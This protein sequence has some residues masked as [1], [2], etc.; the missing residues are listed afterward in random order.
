LSH[1]NPLQRHGVTRTALFHARAISR[2]QRVQR[3]QAENIRHQQ[4]LMLLLVIDADLD[5]P[6]DLRGI[7]Q[8]DRKH[9]SQPSIDMPAIGMD[10]IGA[11]P[12]QQSAMLARLPLAL[13]LI[14]GIEAEVEPLVEDAIAGRM[15]LENEALEEPGRVRKVPLGGARVVHRLDALILR[16]QRRGESSGKLPCLEEPRLEVGHRPD[17]RTVTNNGACWHKT[18]PDAR[19]ATERTGSE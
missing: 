18:L 7:A 5:K 4:F 11:R 2:A 3:E 19:L 6:R 16:T 14:I 1:E 17:V 8:S 15:G 12:R 13:R 10:F 9:L